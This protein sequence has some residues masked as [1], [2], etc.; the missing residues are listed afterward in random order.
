MY[1]TVELPAKVGQGDYAPAEG[2]RK[3]RR[4]IIVCAA[5][6]FTASVGAPV[7]Y[8]LLSGNGDAIP[9]AAA[10]STFVRELM[11]RSP[12]AR[13][14]A[15]LIKTKKKLAS[16]ML[17]AAV[18]PKD[19]IISL[20][21]PN[22]IF[23]FASPVSPLS[24]I[25]LPKEVVPIAFNPV[26]P[27]DSTNLPLVESVGGG[28]VPLPPAGGGGIIS[29]PGT[30]TPVSPPAL[31]AVPEPSTWATMLF[32]FVLTGWALRRRPARKYWSTAHGKI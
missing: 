6:I 27:A 28:G 16:A 22:E 29:P 7:T 4:R 14:R 2:A 30:I 11:D 21:V 15:E 13:S 24:D 18:V 1:E 20:A 9:G 10:A 26:F 12:G 3:L 19:K 25:I 17:S 8:A 23:D 31:T 5:A 32:G